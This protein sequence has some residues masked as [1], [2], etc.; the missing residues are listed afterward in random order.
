MQRQATVFKKCVLLIRHDTSDYKIMLIKSS[1]HHHNLSLKD[2][3]L[4]KVG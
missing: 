3:T 4:P 2:N 1:L